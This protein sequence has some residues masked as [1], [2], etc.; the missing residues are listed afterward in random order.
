M[1][2]IKKITLAIGSV[3]LIAASFTAPSAFSAK[4]DNQGNQ[5]T[6]CHFG[7]HVGDFV[8]LNPEGRTGLCDNRGGN[9]ITVGEKACENGHSAEQIFSSRSCSDGILQN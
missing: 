7:G 1:M 5:V 4:D 9:A 3:A 2:H 8:T 6:I